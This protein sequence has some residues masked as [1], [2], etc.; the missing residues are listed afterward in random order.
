MFGLSVSLFV[1]WFVHCFL[2]YSSVLG[3]FKV[4]FSSSNIALVIKLRS[5]CPTFESDHLVAQESDHLVAQESLFS[6]HLV[7]C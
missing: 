4:L 5:L 1:G 6:S 2:A 7:A 3:L